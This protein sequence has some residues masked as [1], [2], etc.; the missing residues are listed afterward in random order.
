[1]NNSHKTSKYNYLIDYNSK[2][3]LFNGITGAG[4]CMTLQEYEILLPL[5]RDLETFKNDFPEDFQRLFRL[6]YIVESDFDEIAYIRFKN[7]ESV[8]L[9]KS[10]RIIINPTLD[11]NFH[12]WYCYQEHPKGYMDE[13]TISKIKNHL[14]LKIENKEIS[15]LNL[16]WFGGEPLLYFYEIVY[17]LSKFAKELCDT[18]N[19]P[20]ISTI[21]TN[22][23]CMD[24][25]MINTFNEIGLRGFQITL[26]G[27]REKHN[28]V[29]NANGTPS[30]DKIIE[31]VNLLCEKI[32]NIELIL[33][34]N[35]DKQ[36]LKRNATKLLQDIKEKNRNKI[37]IDLQQVWQ[38]VSIQENEQNKGNTQVQKFIEEA[39]N[40]G[41]GAAYGSG[42]L[43]VGRFHNCYVSR[44]NYLSVNC[45]GKIYKCTARGYTNQYVIGNF[46][47]DGT[48][49]WNVKE[50]S[51]LYAKATF[52]NT[53]C[54]NC[55]FLP[56]CM[57]PCPQKMVEAEEQ[58]IENIC[59][60]KLTEQ[61]VKEKII[62]LYEFS[63]KNIKR[64]EI[65]FINNINDD[66]N[67]KCTVAE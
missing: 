58:N 12:C 6:G 35:Y 37:H 25:K 4:F 43:S 49:K 47:D 18:N 15:S 53:M 36:T 40:A 5:L 34:V 16:S 21:T 50:L 64:N 33:R 28:K 66:S 41:F 62:D 14:R 31:N 59:V 22:A 63:L 2:K 48:I 1:M 29:R 54:L 8:Y 60:M 42:G 39:N 65:F 44:Y 30:Y 13:Q 45:D 38:V 56:I 20:F 10:Y 7:K 23:Y 19:I 52:E 26:D 46:L 24:E 51:K 61:S 11:C 27:H 57:G 9:D 67:A 32:K 17:P 3:L 55:T